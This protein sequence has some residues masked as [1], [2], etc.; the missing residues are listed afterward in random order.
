MLS[1]KPYAFYCLALQKWCSQDYK[2][3]G[4]WPDY[5]D[6]TFPSYCS[7]IPFDLDQLKQ[8][9]KYNEILEKWYDCNM[10]DTIALY[11][12]EWLKHGTC[13]A[14]QT[15]LTQNQFFEKTLELFESYSYLALSEIYFDLNFTNID[16]YN[17]QIT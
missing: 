1:M 13:V 6:A 8:S 4:L 2:I 15:G 14:V 16:N 12:H 17:Y 5:N 10:D 11:E 9:P 7:N 3:H